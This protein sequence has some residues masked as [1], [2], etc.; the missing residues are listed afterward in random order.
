ME[1]FDGGT[2]MEPDTGEGIIV[3]IIV[4]YELS[5]V[6]LLLSALSIQRL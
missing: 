3:I 4:S 5:V 1:L 2:F 6:S